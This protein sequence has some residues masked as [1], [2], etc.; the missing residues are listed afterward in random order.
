MSLSHMSL[1]GPCWK[2]MMNNLKRTL[3]VVRATQTS[4]FLRELAA[5]LKQSCRIR[6]TWTLPV[7]DAVRIPDLRA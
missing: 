7:I 5:I 6:I 4:L 1:R 2:R 3:N